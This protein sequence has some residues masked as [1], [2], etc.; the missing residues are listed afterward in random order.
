LSSFWLLL[1]RNGTER[2]ETKRKDFVSCFSNYYRDITILRNETIPF[3]VLVISYRWT[4]LSYFVP[5]KTQPTYIC[6]R[7]SRAI[8]AFGGWVVYCTTHGRFS[9]CFHQKFAIYFLIKAEIIDNWYRNP[10][11]HVKTFSNSSKSRHSIAPLW[12]KIV[13]RNICGPES[14]HSVCLQT[15]KYDPAYHTLQKF[16]FFF[17]FEEQYL[18]WVKSSRNFTYETTYCKVLRHCG[19]TFTCNRMP[20]HIKMVS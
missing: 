4:L 3:R 14:S 16:V 6:T 13:W 20:Y 19:T 15:C 10:T 11:S 5:T 2:N 1:K 8:W 12:S 7:C 17:S 9:A 18:V